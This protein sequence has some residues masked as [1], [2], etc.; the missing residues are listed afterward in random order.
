ME[1]GTP[2]RAGG[3]S[4]Y[5][6]ASV[7]GAA[8]ATVCFPF[9]SLIVALLLLGS[10]SDPEKRSDLR[11]WAWASAVWTVVPVVLLVWLASAGP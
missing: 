1:A 6:A 8:L 4:G 2:E 10:E 11:A 5:G 7:V 3:A 9:I